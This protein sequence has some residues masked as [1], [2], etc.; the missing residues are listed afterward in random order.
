M[1]NQTTIANIAAHTMMGDNQDYTGAAECMDLLVDSGDAIRE[2]NADDGRGGTYDVLYT[3]ADGSAIAIS[4]MGWDTVAGWEDSVMER[5]DLCDSETNETHRR[6]T[7][8]ERI[9]S[10]DA[11]NDGGH[12]E[13]DLGTD[14][15]PN[16]RTCYVY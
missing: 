4:G 9:E 7:L 3:L 5:A 11:D 1:T 12:I 13:V 14:H 16:V 10:R 6:A 2:S 15:C 8:A